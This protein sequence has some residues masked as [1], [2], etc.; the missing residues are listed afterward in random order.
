[1]LLVSVFILNK[2]TFKML[3]PFQL[4][5]DNYFPEISMVGY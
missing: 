1:M 3:K 2:T 5:I 4:A